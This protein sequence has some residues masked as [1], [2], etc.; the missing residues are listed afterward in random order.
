MHTDTITKKQEVPSLK[1]REVSKKANSLLPTGTK[2][3]DPNKLKNTKWL[4]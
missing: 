3:A 4:K 2:K 1:E